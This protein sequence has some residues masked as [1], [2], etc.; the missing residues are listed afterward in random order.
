KLPPPKDSGP[1]LRDW[2][3]DTLARGHAEGD[4]VEWYGAHF[5]IASMQDGR[6]ARVSVALVPKDAT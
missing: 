3:T 6:I 4:G 1:A 2:L 5:E